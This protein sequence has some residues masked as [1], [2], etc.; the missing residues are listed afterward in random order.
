MRFA[1]VVAAALLAAGCGG[2]SGAETTANTATNASPGEA[3]FVRNC[4][5]C[6]ELDAAN[7]TGTFG[8][9]LDE[10]KPSRAEVLS[11]IEDGPGTM[12]EDIVTGRDAQ[13]V[14]DYVGRVAGS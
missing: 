5:A 11:A 6:H 4:G 7:T 8:G 10:L 9:D 3:L 13:V 2:G 12:P 14:A 1:L